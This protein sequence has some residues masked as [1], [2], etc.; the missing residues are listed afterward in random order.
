MVVSMCYWVSQ[1]IV[2]LVDCAPDVEA[3]DGSQHVVEE[4]ADLKV[5]GEGFSRYICFVKKMT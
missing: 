5:C 4:V 3:L 1:N 2:D